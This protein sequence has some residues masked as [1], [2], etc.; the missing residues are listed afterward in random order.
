MGSPLSEAPGGD[1]GREVA[2]VSELEV[3][4]TLEISAVDDGAVQE[5]AEAEGEVVH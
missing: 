2:R 1:V 4:A 3:K 5:L